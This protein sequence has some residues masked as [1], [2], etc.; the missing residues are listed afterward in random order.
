MTVENAILNKKGAAVW[1]RTERATWFF[2]DAPVFTLD[3][4]QEIMITHVLAVCN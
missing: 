4:K 2:F 3:E 1:G